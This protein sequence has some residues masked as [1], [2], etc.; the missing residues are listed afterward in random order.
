VQERS[1]GLKVHGCGGITW[2]NLEKRVPND[3]A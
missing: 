1:C 3:D 2:V